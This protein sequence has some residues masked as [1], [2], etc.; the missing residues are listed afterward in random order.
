MDLMTA[1]GLPDGDQTCA[2]PWQSN[3]LWESAAH[4]NGY[5]GVFGNISVDRHETKKRA[6]EVCQQLGQKGFRGREKNFPLRTWV[7]DIQNPPRLPL[8]RK[9]RGEHGAS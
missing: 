2:K 4:L 9:V 3:A 8:E 1:I 6:E 5:D 7:S